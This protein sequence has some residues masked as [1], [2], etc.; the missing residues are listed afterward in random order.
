MTTIK[1]N[2]SNE[3]IKKLVSSLKTVQKDLK[4]CENEITK[5]LVEKGVNLIQ[6]NYANTS[7]RPFDEDYTVV[8]DIQGNK[9]KAYR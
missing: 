7:E 4:K 5:E 8:S 1:T 9:G 2:L 3:S 6:E